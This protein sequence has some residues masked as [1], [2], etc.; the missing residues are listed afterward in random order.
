MSIEEYFNKI[1]EISQNIENA[2]SNLTMNVDK[3][4]EIMTRIN[5]EERDYIRSFPEGLNNLSHEDTM[6]EFYYI[7]NKIG[8][9]FIKECATLS[10]QEF[11]ETFK[12]HSVSYVI[13]S[14]NGHAINDRIA[15]A[16]DENNYFTIFPSRVQDSEALTKFVQNCIL[17]DNPLISGKRTIDEISGA[18]HLREQVIDVKSE[19][20]KN[21]QYCS[22]YDIADYIQECCNVRNGY[23]ASISQESEVMLSV[24]QKVHLSDQGVFMPSDVEVANTIASYDRGEIDL[25]TM[26]F[27]LT[28]VTG[29]YHEL[30]TTE[31]VMEAF[32]VSEQ[33]AEK[34]FD[35]AIID[36]FG[37]S[38][39]EEAYK[40]FE[41]EKENGDRF[42]NETFENFARY[43]AIPYNEEPYQTYLIIKNGKDI[44]TDGFV[45]KESL[46]E[47]QQ[48]VLNSILK[49]EHSIE[50]IADT[51]SDRKLED[52]NKVVTEISEEIKGKSKENEQTK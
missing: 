22:D 29:L 13:Q 14:R 15:I 20:E 26:V 33:E 5:Q 19:I 38:S 11:E 31:E 12:N 35:D 23:D 49:S 1:H 44:I 21:L 39:F 40:K 2:T 16:L 8:E 43:F 4:F 36:Y 9:A 42:E 7:K 30:Q 45:T 34:M 18:Y 17:A 27:E 10:P 32:G 50:E 3:Y 41:E 48:Q 25:E 24:L 47:E 37:V 6:G 28:N 46:T 52:I 51:V